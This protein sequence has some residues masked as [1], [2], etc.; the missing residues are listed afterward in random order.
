MLREITPDQARQFVGTQEDS[1][2]T[3]IPT[4]FGTTYIIVM[5]NAYGDV[6]IIQSHITKDNVE[7]IYNI[8]L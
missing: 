2:F 1:V 4:G 8:V 7:K 3:V 6:Q 5:H